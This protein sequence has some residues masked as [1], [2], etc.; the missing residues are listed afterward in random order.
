MQEKDMGGPVPWHILLDH[1]HERINERVHVQIR[2][3]R[4]WLAFV[5]F[6]LISWYAL[7]ILD[8][9]AHVTC[10]GIRAKKKHELKELL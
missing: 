6:V 7:Y 3:L 2:S 10:M 9:M 5:Y 4:Q 1:T 8:K